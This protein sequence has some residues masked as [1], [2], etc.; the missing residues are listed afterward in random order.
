MQSYDGDVKIMNIDCAKYIQN[1]AYSQTIQFHQAFTAFSLNDFFI[2]QKLTLAG[3]DDLQEANDKNEGHQLDQPIEEANDSLKRKILLTPGE[4]IFL[5]ILSKAN[6]CRKVTFD[7]ACNNLQ[8]MNLGHLGKE[9]LG[10]AKKTSACFIKT[11]VKSLKTT[12]DKVALINSLLTFYISIDAYEMLLL[13]LLK[14]QP[15]Y[16]IKNTTFFSFN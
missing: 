9:H 13:R 16:K 6:I 5:S 8:K 10:A 11:Q 12:K 3:F 14:K 1:F 4:F 15:K 2:K 7:V